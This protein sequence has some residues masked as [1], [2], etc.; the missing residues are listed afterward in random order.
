[1]AKEILSV[2]RFAIVG[3][4]PAGV[5]GDTCVLTTDGHLY[6]HDGTSW[7]DNGAAGGG[8]GGVRGFAI[9]DFGADP[10][11]CDAVVVVSDATV[12]AT[13]PIAVSVSPINDATT[14]NREEDEQVAEP[15]RVV[16]F[17]ISAGVGFSIRAFTDQGTVAGKFRVA[18]E[19]P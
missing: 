4:L 12:L 7:V 8:G 15:L 10:A 16:A 13:H 5:K 2:V 19:H 17:G 3:S 1:M 11:A 9:V 14:D 18:W 6:T